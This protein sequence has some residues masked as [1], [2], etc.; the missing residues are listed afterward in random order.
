MQTY[1]FAKFAKFES[2]KDPLL[3]HLSIPAMFSSD[4]AL[5]CT[6][7]VVVQSFC[8]W[9]PRVW[10]STLKWHPVYRKIDA[11]WTTLALATTYLIIKVYRLD[12]LL[13]HMTYH[14]DLPSRL[15]NNNRFDR[16]RQKAATDCRPTVNE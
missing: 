5:R 12:V 14:G 10:E 4:V 11:M 15:Y 13:N 3:V 9:P 8:V 16:H 2:V 6:D 7:V 1:V